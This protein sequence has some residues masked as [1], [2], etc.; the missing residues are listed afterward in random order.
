MTGRGTP[1]GRFFRGSELPRLLI[2]AAVMV[3]GWGSVWQLRQ[4]S[5]RSPPSRR[6]GASLSP[7]PVVPD[8]ADR[9]RDGHRPDA[10]RSFATTPPTPTLHRERPECAGRACRGEPPRYPADPLWEARS[11]TAACRFTCWARPG[12]C[13]AIESKLSKTGWLYEAW[14]IT[15]DA[16]QSTLL[17]RLRGSRPRAFPWD[18]TCPSGSSSTATSS[19]S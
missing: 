3:V 2:L 9:V 16:T 1:S 11:S 4:R 8:R 14:I 13:S 18:R 12:G 15:P 7:E 19:R 10:D 5:G 17:V 6:H